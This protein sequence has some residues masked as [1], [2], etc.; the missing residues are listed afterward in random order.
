MKNLITENQKGKIKELIEIELLK[1]GFTAK[2]IEFNEIEGRTGDHYG[3][4][5]TMIELNSEPFQTIPVI[6]KEIKITNFST[7]VKK[8]IIT[9]SDK[10]IVPITR[11]WIQI[12]ASY[13]LF[14]GGSNCT[15]LFEFR[16]ICFGED[17]ISNVHIN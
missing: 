15:A 10:T 11:V 5:K 13:E 1:R 17:G 14:D 7:S 16:C 8:S 9:N 2:L 3:E 4:T 6:F 12:Y